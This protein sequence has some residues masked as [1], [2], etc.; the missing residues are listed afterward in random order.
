[1]SDF[2]T[3]GEVL[4]IHSDQIERYGGAPGV[5][6]AGALEAGLLR[7]Q[8]GNYND[9]IGEAPALWESLGQYHPFD[10]NKRTAFPATYTFLAINGARF[11]GHPKEICAFIARLYAVNQFRVERL[12]PWLR[13]HVTSP[14]D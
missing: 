6:D 7:P 2:L 4:A 8:T 9:L 11:P 3:V 1:M 12:V 10:G 14:R 13:R 5:R